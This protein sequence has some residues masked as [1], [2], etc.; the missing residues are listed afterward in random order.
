MEYKEYHLQIIFLDLDLI[1]FHG[2][3]HQII[4]FFY[5][6]DVVMD[7]SVMKVIKL[8]LFYFY[9]F[10]LFMKYNLIKSIIIILIFYFFFL[11]LFK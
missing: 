2:L 4:I 5:L 11:G 10:E 3:I 7:H 9:F 6:E 1:Q 8:L